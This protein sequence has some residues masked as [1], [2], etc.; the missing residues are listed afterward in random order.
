MAADA[1]DLHAQVL[2]EVH[3]MLHKELPGLLSVEVQK[4]L[5]E[6]RALRDEQQRLQ[7]L[8][9]VCKQQVQECLKAT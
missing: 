5:L 4:L 8:Q 3:S 9:E 2:Q 7:Q 1:Q 6:V